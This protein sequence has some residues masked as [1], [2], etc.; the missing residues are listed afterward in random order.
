M[1]KAFA[2]IRAHSITRALSELKTEHDR[3]TTTA[4]T[5]QDHS[6]YYHIVAMTH[7]KNTALPKREQRIIRARTENDQSTNVE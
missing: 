3:T 5:Q 6:M 2:V 4:R 7:S 1:I